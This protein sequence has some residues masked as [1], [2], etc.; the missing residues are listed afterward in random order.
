M[1]GEWID[2]VPV[3]RPFAL[4]G[5]RTPPPASSFDLLTLVVATGVG[6]PEA[7]TGLGPEH[8]RLLTLVRRSRP[9]AEV[10]ADL[11]LPLGVLRLLLADLRDQG[12]IRSRAPKPSGSTPRADLLREVLDGLKT[13]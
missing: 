2:D 5:G 7:A 12:L 3:V 8:R 11:D 4:A 10:A 9:V 6:V 13:L 1:D